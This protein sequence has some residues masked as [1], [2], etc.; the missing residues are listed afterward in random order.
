MN[1]TGS[2]NIV[3]LIG[4]PV[5][6][7]FSPQMHNAA[8]KALNLDYTYVAFDVNPADLKTAINGAKSLNI[9]GFNVTIP[10]KINV[11]NYLNTLDDIAKL[12]G[13]VNTI[14]FKNLKG[15]NTD[16]IGAIKAIEEIDSVKNKNIVIA[17]AG[18]ASRAISFYLAKYGA[19]KITI[20]NR[21]IDKAKNLANDILNSNLIEDIKTDSI[22][23]INDYLNDSN[24]L[25]NTT[26]V[27]MSPNINDKPIATADNMHEDLIVFD[28]VYNPNETVLLKEAIKAN[29]KPVYGIKMLLYQGAESFKIWTGQNPPIDVM[30]EILIKTLNLK[31]YYGFNFWYF[32][33]RLNKRRI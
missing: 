15:Y 26:P 18:G 12:I 19:D 22:S 29:A 11:I 27:G 28:A 10:H 2:T 13:A 33:Y 30:E 21:N 1:I 3:G 4:N 32:K 31:W 7:S 25:I 23:Q 6:H 17:G 20:L 9:K 8:F 5:E 24:I 16:G 14:D